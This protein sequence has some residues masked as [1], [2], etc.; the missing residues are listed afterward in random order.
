MG[1][2]KLFLHFANAEDWRTWLR[3]NYATQ[4]EVWLIYYKNKTGKQNISYEA[5]VEEALC[6]GWIDSI[7]KKLDEDRYARKYTPRTNNQNWSE[8][9]IRRVKKLMSEG[10]M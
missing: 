10:K 2:Q 7:I 4:S 8:L 1:T 6:F 3:E 5:S 9:N